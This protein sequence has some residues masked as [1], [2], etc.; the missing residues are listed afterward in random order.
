MLAQIGDF[1]KQN[2]SFTFELIIGSYEM[3][4]RI[5][6][7]AGNTGS[8]SVNIVVESTLKLLMITEFPK[9]SGRPISH[10]LSGVVHTYRSP[11]HVTQQI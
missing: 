6:D 5:D 10:V 9:G 11:R 1:P 7:E 8:C 3:E 2:G 4:V